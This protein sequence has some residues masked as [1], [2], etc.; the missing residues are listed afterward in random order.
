MVKR[1]EQ[2]GAEG[3]PPPS[4]SPL[5]APD[6]ASRGGVPSATPPPDDASTDDP[7]AASTGASRRPAWVWGTLL[8]SGV[9]G[10]VPVRDTD[11]YWHLAAG[12]AM[13]A[14]GRLQP[15]ETL[16][17]TAPAAHWVDV[18]WFSDLLLAAGW[19]ALGPGIAQAGMAALVGLGVTLAVHGGER[20]AERRLPHGW[21]VALAWV[22]ASALSLRAIPRPDL[23]QAVLAPALLVAL[24]GA[25]RGERRSGWIAG[26]LL[27]AWVHLHGSM[28]L[29]AGMA[30]LAVFVGRGRPAVLWPLAMGALSLLVH[31]AGA[32]EVVHTV[33]GQLVRGSY[34][35]TVREWGPL[36]WED[37]GRAGPL[38]VLLA[39]YVGA[40]F[41]LLHARKSLR[42]T[43][44]L[45]VLVAAGLAVGS[46]HTNRLLVPAVPC[47]LVV[48]ALAM[49]RGRA[50]GTVLA[51][52][53]DD[54]ASPD[55]TAGRQQAS[56]VLP[57]R[58]GLLPALV[59]VPAALALAFTHPTFRPGGG[60][61]ARAW[62]GPIVA[63][64]AET[65][66]TPAEARVFT[67]FMAGAAVAWGAGVR[68]G[69]DARAELAYPPE[70]AGAYQDAVTTPAGWAS[71]Q[72]RNPTHA[73]VVARGAALCDA[74]A[75]VDSG[76]VAVVG[77]PAYAL[78]VRPDHPLAERAMGALPICGRPL[79][80][81][82]ACEGAPA[83]QAQARQEA[84][85]LAR[86]FPDDAFLRAQAGLVG[87]A[88]GGGDNASARADLDAGVALAPRDPLVRLA[89]GL[90]LR[91]L[92]DPAW[93]DDLA[94][95]LWLDGAAADV[96]LD[97]AE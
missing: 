83:R 89:R 46:L 43:D 40:G 60:A 57:G 35:I 62:P 92:D 73:A 18:G 79:Q 74:L 2:L 88:C 31:P 71:D 27:A 14:A 84:E 11:L 66:G 85:G 47:V 91:R 96:L 39:L 10:A 55:P 72:R 76:W 42:P 36:P 3:G 56:A 19:H 16:S 20:L 80:A 59:T 38:H 37:L 6:G 93:R 58:S 5:E 32:G 48:M 1:P 67:D 87:I 7:R 9:L 70:V 26:G 13:R 4:R 34:P 17:Y 61:T 90:A 51:A 63:L 78:F 22:G 54:R 24:A 97:A 75:Q 45:P 82:R 50:Q 15:P 77:T 8:A 95:L 86:A 21:A 81:T 53:D 94:A 25:V 23:V 30:L 41:A 68:V 12:E 65:R 52:S 64:L 29:G 69:M 44:A 33:G 28:V 49:A